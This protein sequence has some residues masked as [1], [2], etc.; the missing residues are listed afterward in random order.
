MTSHKDS[1][2][3]A[4][5]AMSY[6]T[7][8]SGKLSASET[9]CTSESAVSEPNTGGILSKLSADWLNGNQSYFRRAIQPGRNPYRPQA[10]IR[11][12]S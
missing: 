7:Y 2:I 5:Y 10:R 11:V 12:E 3:R 1:E 9:I 6:R 4:L 8:I